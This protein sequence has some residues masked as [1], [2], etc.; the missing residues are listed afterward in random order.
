MSD[1]VE[2][3]NRNCAWAS[4][5]TAGRRTQHTIEEEVRKLG[6]YTAFSPAY[7][8]R[9]LDLLSLSLSAWH[10]HSS[11]LFY[12][13][14]LLVVDPVQHF[15]RR[16]HFCILRLNVVDP[17]TGPNWIRIQQG[18]R[19]RIRNPDRGSAGCS[20]LRTEGVSCNLGGRGISKFEFLIKKIHFSALLFATLSLYALYLPL[21][22]ICLVPCTRSPP[23]YLSPWTY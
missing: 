14:S 11:F 21:S 20:L 2:Y 4:T 23:G 10:F 12:F 3:R 7:H 15:L 13:L 17:E 1:T 5:G 16:I 6:R 19:I 9:F 22:L 18:L 8:I